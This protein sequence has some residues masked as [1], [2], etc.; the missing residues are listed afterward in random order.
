MT[1]CSNTAGGAATPPCCSDDGGASDPG[2]VTPTGS[3]R[4]ATISSA[5]SSTG[6]I[7][8]PEASPRPAP[9]GDD[10]TA[11]PLRSGETTPAELSDKAA[12]QAAVA[13]AERD[14]DF[15]M[16]HY[17]ID[18]CPLGDQEHDWCEGCRPPRCVSGWG[19]RDG[20][21]GGSRACKGHEIAAYPA[22]GAAAAAQGPL[23]RV[24]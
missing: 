21:R 7:G 17:K 13:C 14:A 16:F 11:S 1:D 4:D 12:L 10:G 23:P 24:F 22:E 8:V 3:V 9:S 19:R 20:G 18:P 6:S 15:I 2:T 5:S